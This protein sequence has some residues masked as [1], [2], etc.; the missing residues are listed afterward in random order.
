MA[1]KPIISAGLEPVL[2]ILKNHINHRITDNIPRI[3]NK[4]KIIK[5]IPV[6]ID[7]DLEPSEL[8]FN[9]MIFPFNICGKLSI[10]RFDK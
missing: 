2:N 1:S 4:I 5:L 9:L 3:I 8:D 10:I 6:L 7:Q